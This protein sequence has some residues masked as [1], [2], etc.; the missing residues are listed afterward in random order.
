MREQIKH[1]QLE[2]LIGKGGMGEVYRAV[3]SETDRVVAIKVLPENTQAD[4]TLREQFAAEIRSAST[5]GHEN[6][7]NVLDGGD[8]EGTYFMV[9]ELVVGHG[10]DHLLK[11]TRKIVFPAACYVMREVLTGLEYLHNGGIFHRDI[12]PPNI[13]YTENGEVKITDFGILKELGS[14][15]VEG[16]I[17]GTPSYMAPEQLQGGT[18]DHRVDLYAAG[19]VF[20]QMLV[21]FNPFYA[22]SIPA[23]IGKSISHNP[24]P[25][26]TF[27]TSIP[28]EFQAFVDKLIAK[29]MSYRYNRVREALDDLNKLIEDYSIEFGREQFQ[30][31]I[32]DGERETIRTRKL[33]SEKFFF[34]S[35]GA[36][37]RQEIGQRRYIFDV[38]RAHL[39]NPT[40][41]TIKSH[42]DELCAYLEIRYELPDSKELRDLGRAYVSD[43]DDFEV[44]MKLMEFYYAGRYYFHASVMCRALLR[45]R[46]S[47]TVI[48]QRLDEVSKAFQTQFLN[49]QI[50]VWVEENPELAMNETEVKDYLRQMREEADLLALKIRKPLWERVLT[51]LQSIVTPRNLVSLGVALLL[52]FTLPF[53]TG[54]LTPGPQFYPAEDVPE[55]RRWYPVTIS[56]DRPVI[57]HDLERIGAL[58]TEQ[59]R[60]F[61]LAQ[62]SIAQENWAEAAELYHQFLDLLAPRTHLFRE[63]A[64]NTANLE[65][66]LGNRSEA[67]ELYQQAQEGNPADPPLL[68]FAVLRQMGHTLSFLGRQAEA[69]VAFAEMFE[70][71]VGLSLPIDIITVEEMLDY[72]RH[73]RRIGNVPKAREAYARMLPLLEDW[74]KRQMVLDEVLAMYTDIREP[75]AALYF[76]T[77][78]R[79]QTPEEA[80]EELRW[81][82]DQMTKL[83][84]R[85]D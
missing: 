10:L 44:L 30:A 45:V 14:K 33:L 8:D 79:R 37:V 57:S 78:V 73:L 85:V 13:M 32:E 26:Y 62:D 15:E 34:G 84:G 53:W 67:I 21:G 66:K 24:A 81:L 17:V 41:T 65:V 55:V 52:I 23:T 48:K 54:L 60:L 42:L 40:S 12:K 76:F 47:N 74:E 64:F 58:S 1:Y 59:R 61:S 51:F 28:F 6:L 39:L 49:D 25:V 63:A 80:F 56:E 82:D 35:R 4:E 29:D 46:P 16:G 50:K 3:D 11:T 72:P 5:I 18:F 75:D 20:F 77:L 43:P 31:L 83:W 38:F 22:P 36:L 2:E 70:Y 9:M 27:D 71:G 7:V 68:R 69:E 19:V